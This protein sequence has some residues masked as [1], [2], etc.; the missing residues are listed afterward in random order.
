MLASIHSMGGD[1]ADSLIKKIN[2]KVKTTEQVSLLNGIAFIYSEKYPEK[3]LDYAHKASKLAREIE[4][5]HGLIEALINI[6]WIYKVN[7]NHTQ[8]LKYL[9]Q[10][11]E[12]SKVLSDTSQ[13][14]K[15]RVSLAQTY[16]DLKDYRNAKNE[17]GQINVPSLGKDE[18]IEFSYIMGKTCTKTGDYD[19]A[20]ENYN[21]LLSTKGLDDDIAKA[22]VFLDIGKLYQQRLVYTEAQNQFY[23]ALKIFQNNKEY[24]NQALTYLLLGDIN[25]EQGHYENALDFNFKA[26]AIYNDFGDQ[27]NKSICY[28]KIGLT[29]L[30]QNKFER[31]HDYF[32][33]SLD[34]RK[35]LGNKLLESQSYSNIAL[36]YEQQK[37]ISKAII[38]YFKSIKLRE[39]IHDDPEIAENYI[40]LAQ[41]Y[42]HN[43]QYNKAIEMA[44]KAYQ[45]AERFSDRWW[46]K[47]SAKIL[48]EAN[49]LQGNYKEGYHFFETYARMKDS[50][51]SQQRTEQI[52]RLEMIYE[53][54]K[55][56]KE[57]A[58]LSSQRKLDELEK[59]K[60]QTVI[61]SLIFGVGLMV[62]LFLFGYRAYSQKNKSNVLLA[63]QKS[64]IEK[65][66]KDIVSSLRYAKRIQD[67]ILPK[68][69]KLSGLFKDAFVLYMPKEI[70]SGDFYWFEQIQNKIV[71]AVIDCTGH[72][73][74]GAFMSMIANELLND[75]V[76][77]HS[78]TD[79][80]EILQRLHKRVIDGLKKRE[81][82]S[83]TVDGMNI[84]LCTLD[85]DQNILQFSSSSRPLIHIRK[86]E[87]NEI[88]GNK[89]PIGM[90]LR[91][92]R[93]FETK[94]VEIQEDDKFY[95]FT[96]G[97][98]DQFGGEFYEKLT[99]GGLCEQLMQIKNNSMKVQRQLLLDFFNEWK[100]G[101]MQMDD[102]CMIGIKI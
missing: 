14:A 85:K 4:Y 7:N 71:F 21:W 48:A 33:Q 72:G 6:G 55:K 61:N 76:K 5:H 39:E 12:G 79:P 29:Y 25:I 45:I 28:D 51:Y 11:K 68:Q 73:V 41:L 15:I 20:I 88:Q 78:I 97:Y 75:I 91:K 38:Y 64:I 13:L 87:L 35:N 2:P 44:E 27:L 36:A 50:L 17:L 58:I 53:K 80:G 23:K 22:E 60:Q 59:Q 65:K 31:A 69:Q 82:E 46:I 94:I 67:A 56:E 16:Y 40:G 90:V 34:L 89:F 54:E 99:R 19:L 47:E 42:F 100:K 74:P 10:A 30:H 63:E 26:L 43:G 93:K 57:I 66:N 3:A 24:K 95:I 37:D 101:T 102:V 9:N 49:Q 98:T 62:L 8:A 81:K 86:N 18:R 92:P 1:A 77:N 32:K 52:T 83:L 84:A 70:V 96:D